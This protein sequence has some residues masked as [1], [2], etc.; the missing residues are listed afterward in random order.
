MVARSEIMNKLAFVFPGQ[1]SQYVGMGKELV[2]KYSI[3]QKI[4][5]EASE[6]MGYDMKKLCF[7]GPEEELIKTENTQPAILTVSI[8]FYNILIQ[9]NI[10][11]SV[12]AGLSLGEYSAL[13]SAGAINFKDGL[14]LVKVRGKYM[15]EEVP[16]GVGGM[17]AI[18]GLHKEKVLEAC[19][20]ASPFGIVEPANYN[21]PIQTVISG[22]IKAVEE[23]VKIC[24]EFGAKKAV[25]LPVSAPFHSSLLV[26]AGEKLKAEL[27]SIDI[28]DF[29]YKIIS[30][31]TGDYYADK[32]EIKDLLIQQVSRPVLWEN[33]VE[34]MIRDGIDTFIEVGPGKVLSGFI[35]R[36]SKDVKVFNIEDSKSLNNILESIKR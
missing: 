36:I 1:G 11:P 2:E 20:K 21:S 8:A 35:K 15:Q 16:L 12:V 4:F 14:R 19:S 6:S 24:K 28:K 32:K 33:T 10:E 25:M 7:E 27:D 3:A 34:R 31:V 5:D 18:I 9:Y 17:A 30:N 23:A 29:K 22:E 13:V 26:G